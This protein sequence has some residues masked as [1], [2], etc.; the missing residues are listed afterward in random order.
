[1]KKPLTVVMCEDPTLFSLYRETGGFDLVVESDKE[2]FDY[3]KLGFRSK[4]VLHRLARIFMKK[5]HTFVPM[6]DRHVLYFDLKKVNIATL[7][8]FLPDYL[9][10]AGY[11]VLIAKHYDKRLTGFED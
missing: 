8:A 7:L 10:E 9:K 11:Q 3:A 5:D 1:M 4:R 2:R 6:M